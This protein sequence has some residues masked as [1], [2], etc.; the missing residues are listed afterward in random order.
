MKNLRII[1][2]TIIG[3]LICFGSNAQLKVS[4]T[5]KTSIQLPKGAEWYN[6]STYTNRLADNLESKRPKENFYKYTYKYNGMTFKFREITSVSNQYLIN[7]QKG[8]NR[9]NKKEAILKEI[10]GNHILIDD[11]NQNNVGS[12]RFFWLNKKYTIGFTGIITYNTS[13][14]NKEYYLNIINGII[15]TIKFTE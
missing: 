11:S 9:T 7:V 2:L 14:N 3:L 6:D 13:N 15:N 1:T 10:N 12:Y 4:L 8:L 5:N